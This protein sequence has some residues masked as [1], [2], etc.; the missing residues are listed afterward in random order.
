MSGFVGIINLDRAPV[1]RDLLEEL[2]RSMDYRGPDAQEIRIL[3]HV[4]LGH[5]MLRTTWE[6]ERER[7]PCSLDGESWITADCRVDARE[8]L[9]R[10]LAAHGRP[11][12]H[13]ATDPELI[14]H[15][16]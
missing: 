10:D 16:Y 1:N 3:D 4:G 8:D 2:T 9:I 7:Q 6:A 5:A 11:E 13:G 12:A 15:A 14:L